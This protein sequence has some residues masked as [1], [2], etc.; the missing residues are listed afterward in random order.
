MV[1]QLKWHQGARAQPS[2][3]IQ[4]VIGIVVRIRSAITANDRLARRAP[5]KRSAASVSTGSKGARLCNARAWLALTYKEGELKVGRQDKM[6]GQEAMMSGDIHEMRQRAH[7]MG[8][9]GSSRMTEDQLRAAM[10]MVSKG[11]DPMMAKREA[12]GRM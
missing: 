11:S 8:I 12:K 7:E 6:P 4:A 5:R 1:F 10:K 9:E 2:A 3:I